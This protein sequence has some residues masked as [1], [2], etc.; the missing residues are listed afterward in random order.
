ML[1][2]RLLTCF[3]IYLWPVLDFCSCLCVP[4]SDRRSIRGTELAFHL[5]LKLAISAPGEEECFNAVFPWCNQVCACLGTFPLIRSVPPM[6]L[7]K[8]APSISIF[9]RPNCSAITLYSLSTKTL[10]M[11]CCGTA[12][13]SGTSPES[14]GRIWK[15]TD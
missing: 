3:R 2:T 14:K 15:T 12:E 6:C 5:Q 4:P 7:Q 13:K 10:G 1:F 8:T 9:K 11:F